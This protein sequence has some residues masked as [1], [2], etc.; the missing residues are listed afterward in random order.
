MAVCGQACYGKTEL[1]FQK[2]SR[3]T[4]HP[5]LISIFYFYLHKQPKFS[6]MEI[7]VK[8]YLETKLSF[9][10][11]RSRRLR[12]PGLKVVLN[13]I[14]EIWSV[15]LAYVDKLA[16]KNRRVKY[17]LWLLTVSQGT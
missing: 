6:T 11:Y 3:N 15:Y 2:L 12:L 14:N 9:N 1:I 13:D 4:F 8:T 16:K 17:C 5:N 7:K 10:K